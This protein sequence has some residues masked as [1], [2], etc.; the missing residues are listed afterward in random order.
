MGFTYHD[1]RWAPS[2]PP[3]GT[4]AKSQ[5]SPRLAVRVTNELFS[6]STFFSIYRAVHGATNPCRFCSSLRDA[7]SGRLHLV[8]PPPPVGREFQQVT[9]R[10]AEPRPAPLLSSLR[11]SPPAHRPRHIHIHP[12]AAAVSRLPLEAYIP[13]P[14]LSRCIIA[15]TFS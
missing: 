15:I 13:G 5:D 12:C 7:V 6:S 10:R 9:E 2:T 3:L 14:S 11:H 4:Q 8:R 1:S